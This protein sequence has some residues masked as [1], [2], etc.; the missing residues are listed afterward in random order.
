L[1]LVLIAK[2]P[3]KSVKKLPVKDEPLHIP[4]SFEEIIK[5]AVNTPIKNSKINKK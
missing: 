5:K 3:A 2:K 1:Y 4:L